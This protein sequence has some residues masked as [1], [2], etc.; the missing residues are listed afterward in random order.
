M[1]PLPRPADGDF[2]H[3]ADALLATG[4]VT[5]PWVD[6]QPRFASRPLALPA[7]EVRRLYRA[8]ERVAA[9]FHEA[10]LQVAADPALLDD[11]FALTPVQKLMWASSAPLWHGI[12]R[13]DLFLVESQIVCCELNADTPSG[14]PEAVLLGPAT[15][16]PA[17]RD[18]NRDLEARFGELLAHFLGAVDRRGA[19]D[20]PTV[21]IIYPTEIAGDFALIRLYQRWCQARGLQVVLGSPYNLQPAPGGRVALFGTPCDLFIRHY[22]TDWWGNG[23]RSGPTRIPTPIPIH[24][25]VRWRCCCRPSTPVAARWSILSAPC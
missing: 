22:K 7:R 24:W 9:A 21:G 1:N 20:P 12:A 17:Q 3:L 18:P 8:A 19:T 15:G 13:A 23:C 6:G 25:P 10:A 14:Q 5:D 2:Q 4:L 16:V 11:F